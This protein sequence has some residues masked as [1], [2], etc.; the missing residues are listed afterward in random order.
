MK[1]DNKYI[2]LLKEACEKVKKTKGINVSLFNIEFYGLHKYSE[3]NVYKVS[4]L[5]DSGIFTFYPE[6]DGFKYWGE[7]PWSGQRRFRPANFEDWPADKQLM[8]AWCWA[9]YSYCKNSRDYRNV[10]PPPIEE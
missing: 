4:L 5:T 3:E 8:L 9:I 6:E 10:T 1:V 7:V 2:E